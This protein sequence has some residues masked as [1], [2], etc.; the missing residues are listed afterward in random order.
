M[1]TIFITSNNAPWGRE[2]MIIFG[3]SLRRR[4]HP[5]LFSRKVMKVRSYTASIV[6]SLRGLGRSLEIVGKKCPAEPDS[7]AGST[8]RR[9]ALRISQ[10]IFKNHHQSAGKKYFALI[11][12]SELLLPAR[13]LLR[14]NKPFSLPFS[15]AK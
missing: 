15:P 7:T 10:S 13:A 5:P 14:A 3:D 2:E 11:E 1:A 9:Q 12:H 6:I 4:R 8:Q